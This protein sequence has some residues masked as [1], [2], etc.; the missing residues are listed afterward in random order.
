[1]TLQKSGNL[2][3]PANSQQVTRPRARRAKTGRFSTVESDRLVGLI[4]VFGQALFLFED[5]VAAATE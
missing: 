1:M 3:V 2:T 5:N 4:A